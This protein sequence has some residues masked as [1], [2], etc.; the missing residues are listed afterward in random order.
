MLDPM[1]LRQATDA[2]N[3][4]IG[5]LL[6]FAQRR[7]AHHLSAALAP[8]DLTVSQAEALASL[9]AAGEAVEQQM[10]AR[11]T[12]IDRSTASELVVGLESRGLIGRIAGADRRRKMLQLTPR[13]E[14]LGDAAM[15]AMTEGNRRFAA[16]SGIDE[17]LLARLL[18]PIIARPSPAPA[19]ASPPSP[20]DFLAG[21]HF[22]L[23]RASQ[24]ASAMFE[25]GTRAFD[26]RPF[27]VTVLTV[28]AIGHAVSVSDL[29][30]IAGST[31]S[32][33]TPSIKRLTGRGFVHR[34]ANAADR[35]SA[36][37]SITQDGQ[38][39]FADLLDPIE[40]YEKSLLSPLDNAAQA[41]LRAI[42]L[43]I[44]ASVQG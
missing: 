3:A 25:D 6:R 40:R 14:S 44:A 39:H 24:V 19:Y 15:S 22:L 34:G 16:E 7:S 23:R 43:Q 18:T 9:A 30:D 11:S 12:G 20:A 13:G 37:L 36:L 42:L 1:L 32:V 21:S 2:V 38:A 10:L 4:R 31:R 28:L 35:R 26:T 5:A 27:E 29:Q 41:R 8:I 33:V 17:A